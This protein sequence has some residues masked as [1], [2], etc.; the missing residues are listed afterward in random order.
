VAVIAAV[1]AAVAAVYTG[2]VLLVALELV[3]LGA[4]VGRRS[5]FGCAFTSQCVCGICVYSSACVHTERGGTSFS[6]STSVLSL[7]RKCCSMRS[8]FG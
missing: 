3:L 7:V 4:G 6:V 8:V 1:A 2:R 5:A